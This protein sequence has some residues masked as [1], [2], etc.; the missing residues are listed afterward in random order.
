MAKQRIKI[1]AIS[2]DQ[3]VRLL[4]SASSRKISADDIRI[5]AEN[6]GI[7][8]ADG[9]VNLIAYTAFLAGELSS[10]N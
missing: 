6:P 5:V 2:I 10:G 4:S 3:L 7:T 1:T 9:T 8:N